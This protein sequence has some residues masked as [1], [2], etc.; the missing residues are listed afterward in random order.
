M[1]S[2]NI[3]IENELTQQA[4]YLRGQHKMDQNSISRVLGVSQPHVSRLLKRAEKYGLLYTELRFVDSGMSEEE[5]S[6]LQRLLIPDSLSAILNALAVDSGVDAPNVLVFDSGAKATNNEIFQIRTTRLGQAA[7]GRLD[8]LMSTSRTMGIAWGRTVN[9]IV[10]GLSNL[11]LKKRALPP[12]TFVPVCAELTSSTKRVYSST[13]LAERLDEI[14]NRSSNHHFSLSGVPAYVPLHFDTIKKQVIWEYVSETASHKSIFSGPRPLIN[15]L[16]TVLTSVGSSK[17]PVG[18]A[19]EELA[20]HG[21]TTKKTI[22]N[23][24][25]GDIGGILIPKPDLN[26]REIEKVESLNTM[27]TGMTPSQLHDIAKRCKTNKFGSGSIVIALG[28]ERALIVHEIIRLGLVNELIIDEDLANAL[29]K[30]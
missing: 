18:G 19:I 4:A 25:V 20:K 26:N 3:H 6:R 10:E 5:L 30:L 15:K 7:A 1:P 24:V 22:R 23:M 8:E 28:S 12:I 2:K 14:V 9:A 11:K 21:G 27:W 13:R 17:N 16:D 29:E